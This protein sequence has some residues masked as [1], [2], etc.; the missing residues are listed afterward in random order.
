MPK[1]VVQNAPVGPPP[2]PPPMG[3]GVRPNPALS[4]YLSYYDA[5]NPIANEVA[6]N[7]IP[8]GTRQK[9]DRATATWGKHKPAG[10]PSPFLATSQQLK[11][12]DFLM[13]SEPQ[14]L[15][16]IDMMWTEV[17]VLKTGLTPRNQMVDPAP[18]AFEGIPGTVRAF[19]DLGFCFRCDTRLPVSVTVQGFRR[20]F[21]M[22]PPADIQGTLPHRAATGT[23]MAQQLG[24][25]KDNRDAVNEMNICVSRNLKGS[26]KFP[27]PETT[28][29]A[30][31]YAI[32]LPGEKLGFDTENWQASEVGGLWRPGEKAFFDIDAANVIAYIPITKILKAG[33]DELHRFKFD[34]NQWTYTANAKAVDH[35]VLGPLIAAIYNNEAVQAVKRVDDFLAGQ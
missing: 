31:I 1:P 6:C 4:R 33:P 19:R 17:L 30:Y 10:V 13:L 25:W 23:G 5:N 20:L 34:A 29:T 7:A 15:A 11:V 26:T 28:G 16:L 35:V 24:M 3:G 12:S 14:R 21:E 27:N 2:P 8:L 9:F 22:S 32:K 18:N